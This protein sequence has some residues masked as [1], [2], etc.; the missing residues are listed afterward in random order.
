MNKQMLEARTVAKL[1]NE[2]LTNLKNAE[3]N[4]PAIPVIQVLYEDFDRQYKSM[5]QVEHAP[6]MVYQ[7]FGKK[8][9]ELTPQEFKAYK[10]FLKRQRILKSRELK[11]S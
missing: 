10:A 2:L 11:N 8:T 9:S 3:P 7:M 4:H 6:S 1:A 5:K